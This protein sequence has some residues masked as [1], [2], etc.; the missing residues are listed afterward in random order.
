MSHI[1]EKYSDV[2][3]ELGTL[4]DRTNPIEELKLWEN[5]K[6]NLECFYAPFN[7]VNTSAK[8]VIIGITPG[9]TQMNRA[10][11]TAAQWNHSKDIDEMFVMVKKQGSL[12]GAM[13]SNIVNMLNKLGYAKRL[14]IECSSL[15][16]STEFEDVHFCSLLKYPIFIRGK[17]YNGTP[18][19]LKVPELYELL[20]NEFVKDLQQLPT[21]AE[22]VPLGD[23]VAGV[24]VELDNMGL[25]KQKVFRFE[26]QV[27]APPHPSGANA[28][29]ISLLLS[30]NYPTRDE[31]LEK[32]Y[33]TYLEKQSKQKNANPQSEEKYK[34]AR[35]LRWQRIDFVRKAYRINK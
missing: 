3:K 17:D 6:K 33:S 19:P 31:Y 10:I 2:I 13:R 20:M 22:L 8:L 27:V 12:S 4:S 35:K 29:A 11:S 34:A 16:W 25:I 18:H 15:L 30:E 7:H 5:D 21:D 32:M 9:R 26:G 14:E 1:F 24:L 28:E 23:F